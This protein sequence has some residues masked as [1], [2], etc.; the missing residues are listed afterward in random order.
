MCSSDEGGLIGSLNSTP[1][2]DC[3]TIMNGHLNADM[4]NQVNITVGSKYFDIDSF[5]SKYSKSKKPLYL[6]V[7]IQSLMSKYDSLKSL[8][9]NLLSKQV[10]IDVIALQEIW[11][12]NY[13]ELVHIPGFQPLIFTC[14]VGTRG[15]GVAC[16]L[17]CSMIRKK[18]YS[19]TFI[20][21]LTHL[22][23]APIMII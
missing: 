9:I 5:S 21:P 10:P 11:S 20:D 6:S 22:L 18:F 14:R 8:V 1:D 3:T 23:I 7:N 17:K 16:P 13:S 4:D 2:Y 19:L 15:G 12:I